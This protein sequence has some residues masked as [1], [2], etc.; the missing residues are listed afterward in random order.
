MGEFGIW[1]I[2]TN[3]SHDLK[4]YNSDAIHVSESISQRFDI[5]A[6]ANLNIHSLNYIPDH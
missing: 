1:Y 6:G 3:S 5:M 4:A 2:P